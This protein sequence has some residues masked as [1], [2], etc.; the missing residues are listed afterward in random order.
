MTVSSLHAPYLTPK[1]TATSN[2]NA[3]NRLLYT[4]LAGYARTPATK[5]ANTTGFVDAVC[6]KR[7]SEN[8][9]KSA[10]LE[11]HKVPNCASRKHAYAL[12]HVYLSHSRHPVSLHSTTNISV[13][14]V[15]PLNVD[16]WVGMLLSCIWCGSK[17]KTM[18]S[19]ISICSAVSTKAAS[20]LPFE[21]SLPRY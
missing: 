7:L 18:K 2:G 15:A 14:F 8:T 21:C 10:N 3:C 5:V 19:S 12:P 11:G 1:K 6:V 16:V 20:N 4:Q 17:K 13:H 9:T